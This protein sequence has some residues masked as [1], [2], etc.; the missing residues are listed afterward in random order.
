MTDVPFPSLP[1]FPEIKFREYAGRTDIP[2]TAALLERMRPVDSFEWPVREQDIIEDFENYPESDTKRDLVIAEKD[3]RICAFSQ[4]WWAKDPNGPLLFVYSVNVSP[5]LRDTDIGDVLLEWCEA[6]SRENSKA[7]DPNATKFF[8]VALQDRSAYFA[9][10]LNNHGYWVYRH[11]LSM[12]RPDLENI[13]DFRLPDG[14]E[15]RKALPEHHARIMQA[16]NEACKDMRGQIPISDHEWAMWSKRSS[17]DPAL[18]SI[19]WHGDD[20][21]GTVFGMINPEDNELNK[22]KRGSAELIST[23]KDWRGKGVAKALMAR[24]MHLLSDRGM[25]ECA[26]G[27]DEGNPSGARHLYEKMGFRVTGRATFYRKEL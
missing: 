2:G 21:I 25:T 14:L 18:W 15:I 22:R 13:P 10:L 17:F 7:H 4:V 12:L 8:H 19:A 11:G 27:V 6:R 16:W 20:V 1:D 24:T 3:G 9:G 23:R 5:E 26:L